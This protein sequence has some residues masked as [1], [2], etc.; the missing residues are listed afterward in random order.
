MQG[1]AT[2]CCRQ[3]VFSKLCSFE[4]V[5]TV[6][7]LLQVQMQSH[8]KAPPHWGKEQCD[9]FLKSHLVV[10]FNF[11]EGNTFVKD[12]RNS[13]HCYLEEQF[14]I[15]SILHASLLNL[16]SGAL[17]SGN[18]HSVSCDKYF[19]CPLSSFVSFQFQEKRGQEWSA[20]C[21]LIDLRHCFNL[22]NKWEMPV[23]LIK[24]TPLAVL[25]CSPDA[26]ARAF[27]KRSN[28]A[29]PIVPDFSSLS[30]QHL[31]IWANFSKIVY[32][33]PC[34]TQFLLGNVNHYFLSRE[35]WW[36]SSKISPSFPD[37]KRPSV[38]WGNAG[39]PPPG[40]AGATTCG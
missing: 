33:K 18:Y 35:N 40:G 31:R 13:L 22:W 26:Q 1:M 4:N 17:V 25:V 7:R 15:Y 3:P 32:C 9:I 14:S 6:F 27:V 10:G 11:K 30:W 16:A 5:Q 21:F 34:N 12:H 36:A 28:A 38:S 19:L 8:T 39:W 2:M 29:H 24:R 37:G 20:G 23:G